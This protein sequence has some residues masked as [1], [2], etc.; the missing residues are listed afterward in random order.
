MGVLTLA[1]AVSDTVLA[2]TLISVA[3]G[4]PFAMRDVAQDSLLQ[5]TVAPEVLG[6]IYAAREMFARVAFL[7]GGLVFAVLADQLAI[8]QVY[9]LSGLMYCLV[10]VYALA[11]TVLRRST[12][13][14]PSSAF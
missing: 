11:S 6:R 13:A 2:A 4:P 9:V 7:A 1:Y 10:A 3:F 12:I 8:R 5:T 14:A